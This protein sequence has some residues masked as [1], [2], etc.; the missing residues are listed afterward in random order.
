MTSEKPNPS[1]TARRRRASIGPVSD[2]ESHLPAE[3][4]RDIFDS[5]YLKT[6]GDVVEDEENARLEVDR[7]IAAEV[8]RID[9]EVLPSASRSVKVMR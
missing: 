9:A 3:W 1:R 8:K 4:W 2:L 7:L 5:L 6:D